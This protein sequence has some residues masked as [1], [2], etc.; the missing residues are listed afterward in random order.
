MTID[1]DIPLVHG[2]YVGKQ[3]RASFH[4]RAVMEGAVESGGDKGISEFFP[5]NAC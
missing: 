5:E 4:V 1:P 3:A 2:R